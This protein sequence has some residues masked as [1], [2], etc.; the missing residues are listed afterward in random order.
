MIAPRP[1]PENGELAFRG[2]QEWPPARLTSSQAKALLAARNRCG[3]P[4]ADVLRRR[5]DVAGGRPRESWQID[6]PGHFTDQEAA[7]Y[8]EPFALL[9]AARAGWKNPHANLV[10][11]R[12]LAR[13][14]RY[15]AMP[16]DAEVP[17][18]RWIEDELLP[19]STLIVVPRDDD[20]T[21]GILQSAIFAGWHATHRAR[22]D[23]V[24]VVESFP[25]PWSPRTGLNAL[26]A[27]QEDARHAVARA[28]RA[29]NAPQ[30]DDAVA[31][32]YGWPG[33]MTAAARQEKLAALHCSRGR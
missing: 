8:E 24:S 5:L 30:L 2:E 4:N 12:A 9:I 15:L 27:V 25:F 23:P 11:R 32:A 17:D 6:F 22:L 28:S 19:A 7:L 29:E 26:T 14:S 18:W 33:N 10:L 16:V 31:Q 13:V 21:R 1:L 3:R 20:F